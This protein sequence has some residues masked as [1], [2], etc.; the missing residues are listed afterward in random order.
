[1]HYASIIEAIADRL[2]ESE[3]L[4]HHG[5][6]RHSWAAYDQ[7]AAR[8]ASALAAAGLR[9][10]ATLALFLYNC[11]EYLEAQLAA[12]KQRM[13]PINVNYR[14]V[15]AELQYLLENSDSE[16]LVFHGSLGE[17][18]ARVAPRMPRLRL[19]LQV[20]DGAPLVHGAVAYEHALAAHAPAPRIE[21]RP[22]DLFM[23]YTGGTTG[24]PKGVMYGLGDIS[25]AFANL[26]PQVLLGRPP[27]SEDAEAAEFAAGLH[28][29]GQ[30]MTFLPAS[31]LMHTAGLFQSM[32]LQLLGAKIVTL[33]QRTFDAGALWQAVQ[34][35]H[36]TG[37]V[38]VGDAFA[39]PMI[40]ALRA[41][42]AKGTPYD[43]SSL[44]LVLSSGVMWSGEVKKALLEFGDFTLIDG[45]GAT[46]GA[47]GYQISRRGMDAATGTFMRTADTT[48]FTEDGREIA[49]GSDEA[50]LIAAGGML[51]PRGYYKDPEKSAKTFRIVA[52]KR[53]AFTGDWGKLAADGSLILLGRGSNCINTAGEKVFPEEIEEILKAH[54]QVEDCLV[55]GIPDERFGQRVA[56]VVATHVR[57]D[58]VAHELTAFCKDRMA[59]YKRPRLFLRVDA[60]A[61]L[62]NGKPDYAWARERLLE[63]A[64]AE[65]GAGTP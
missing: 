28:A 49:P 33:P 64:A 29:A 2:P 47:M 12:L 11:P 36:V 50:G 5:S 14:Y 9:P 7:R 57:A 20:N 10:G 46:E 22:D 60:I 52:G 40:E 26:Y 13:T 31:P 15:D 17:T 42:R 62:A 65:A 1:M 21:R 19:L 55:V 43:V 39:R 35:E 41:A 44:R 27:V 58:E 59:G 53:Y 30:A 18:I 48:L 3:A 56:A 8:L 16:A 54:P 4:V 23:M 38:I 37:M 25:A 32:A 51:V 24:M 6:I 45:I 61:R 63:A 34:D